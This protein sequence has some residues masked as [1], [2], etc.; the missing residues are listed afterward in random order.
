MDA[1]AGAGEAA[2]LAEQQEIA[3]Q[4]HQRHGVPDDQEEAFEHLPVQRQA[5][6][7]LEHRQARAQHQQGE[8]HPADPDY[9]T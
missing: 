5:L 1:R 8:E 9:G 2:I 4:Q 7:R 3:A 6:R